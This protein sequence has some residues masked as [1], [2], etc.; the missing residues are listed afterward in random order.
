MPEWTTCLSFGS[1]S[2]DTLAIKS[3]CLAL[4][5]C[6][7]APDS[8]YILRLNTFQTKSCLPVVAILNM[9]KER[10]D[11]VRIFKTETKK[12]SKYTGLCLFAVLSRNERQ[13]FCFKI[14]LLQ[15]RKYFLSFVETKVLLLQIAATF[16]QNNLQL[17]FCTLH[18]DSRHKLR[19]CAP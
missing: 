13:L 7:G 14:G 16:L 2:V 9:C 5:F 6:L 15:F 1:A 11:P 12:S 4:I 18:S 3:T 17:L 8:F 10:L 19:F